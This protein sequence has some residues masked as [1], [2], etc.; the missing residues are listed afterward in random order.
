MC[1]KSNQRRISRIVF[2][3]KYSIS[4]I[5]GLRRVARRF[6]PHFRFVVGARERE[7][8]VVWL[9]EAKG[10][11][12]ASEAK[13]T[14]SRL[15]FIQFSVLSGTKYQFHTWDAKNVGIFPYRSSAVHFITHLCAWPHSD[16]RRIMYH[17]LNVRSFVH[18][19]FVVLFEKSNTRCFEQWH[20]IFLRTRLS[21]MTTAWD[22]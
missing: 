7:R 1:K 11:L 18:V 12:Y 14:H 22:D 13:R 9:C 4:R 10:K 21:V 3:K 5:T 8:A 19:S 6:P 15:L 20:E 2:F 17:G 16:S